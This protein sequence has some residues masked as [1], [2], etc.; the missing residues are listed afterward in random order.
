MHDRSDIEECRLQEQV[1]RVRQL[2]MA[3]AGFH[4][5]VLVT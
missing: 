4:F 5:T 1:E 2:V 3:I